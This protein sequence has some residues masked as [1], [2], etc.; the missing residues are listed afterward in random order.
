MLW[1]RAAILLPSAALALALL[2]PAGVRADDQSHSDQGHQQDGHGDDEGDGWGDGGHGGHGGHGGGA[3]P[4][5]YP[6]SLGKVAASANGITVF[7]IAP[8]GS[9]AVVSGNGARMSVSTARFSV[10]IYCNS[11]ACARRNTQL[12]IGSTGTPTGRLG[13][14]DDFTVAMGSA[15]LVSGPIGNNPIRFTLGPM[16]RGGTVT[17]FIG[18]DAP[19]YGDDFAGKPTGPASSAIY[20]A[21]SSSSGRNTVIAGAALTANVFRR[22]TVSQ[23]SP[24]TFGTIVKPVAGSGSVV[25]D[26]ST[27]AYSISGGAA[28]SSPIPSRGAFGVT[29]EGGQAISIGVP[30]SFAM[31]NGHGDTISVTTSNTASG[32]QMLSNAPGSAGTFTFRVGG[33][34]S[35][36]GATP[37]GAYSGTY[38]VDVA[39]N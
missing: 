39:Y 21:T 37:T 1:G 7:R 25:L 23:L 19:V 33:S 30:S 9:V 31:V 3:T 35:F 17:F 20:V 2:A 10:S 22:L 18:A 27:G 29:G 38:M 8:S 16:G 15:N 12:E 13:S 6:T 4:T 5:V 34:F 11:N 26:A 36:G 32:M 24:L 14:L 28:L